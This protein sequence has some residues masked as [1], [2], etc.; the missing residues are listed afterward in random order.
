MLRQSHSPRWQPPIVLRPP[1]STEQSVF[2]ERIA[3]VWNATRRPEDQRTCREGRSFWFGDES[4]VMYYDLWPK[5]SWGGK[6]QKSNQSG[7][8]GYFFNASKTFVI[9]LWFG[10]ER[11][12]ELTNV[13]WCIAQIFVGKNKNL[14]NQVCLD[15]FLMPPNFC[16]FVMIWWRK[17]CRTYACT[18]IYGP[19]FRGEKQKSIQ[20]GVIG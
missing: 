20:S 5:F 1:I 16:N 15:N 14:F 13:L 3:E 7:V 17:F 8:I 19:N 11:F 12:V 4:F 10:D 9:L 18:M 6:K 2:P